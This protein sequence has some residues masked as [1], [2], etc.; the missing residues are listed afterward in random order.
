MYQRNA[1]KAVEAISSDL[2]VSVSVYPNALS[3]HPALLAVVF[4]RVSFVTPLSVVTD[5]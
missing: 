5:A 1:D 4:L 2:E 3:N